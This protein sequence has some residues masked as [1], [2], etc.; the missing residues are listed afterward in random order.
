MK[1]LAVITDNVT[2]RKRYWQLF[3]CVLLQLNGREAE[4][5]RS[6]YHNEKLI[7][8]D[9]LFSHRLIVSVC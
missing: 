6:L 1:P 2:D 7:S 5:V 9:L 4:R 3:L 8:H